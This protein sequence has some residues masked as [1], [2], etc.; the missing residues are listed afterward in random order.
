MRLTPTAV[1]LAEA[2]A[3]QNNLS[4]SEAIRRLVELGLSAS[5]SSRP[6]SPQ[7]RAKA[8]ALAAETIDRHIDPTAA[9]EEQA[10]RK[11]RLLKGPKEFRDMRKDVK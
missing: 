2:W 5:H 1:R 7:T 9:P 11:R 3:T 4:R 8:A 10:S 6:H